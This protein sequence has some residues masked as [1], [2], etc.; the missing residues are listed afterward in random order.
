MECPY[1]VMRRIKG[2][3]DY[4]RTP[5]GM[6]TACRKNRSHMWG[7][8]IYHESRLHDY[9]TFLTLTYDNDNLPISE[10]GYN[11]LVASHVSD[12]MKRLRYYKSDVKVR[13][14]AGGEYGDH[15]FRPHYHLALFGVAP[16]DKTVFKDFRPAESGY[17]CD[18]RA[19]SYG[20][21]NV[22]ELE[23]GSANYIG[24]YCLK[25]VM[26]KGAEEYYKSRGIVPPFARM[27]NRPGIG[28]D[29]MMMY[30]D[31]LLKN[32]TCQ[33]NG[34]TINLP[35][36]YAEKLHYKETDKF[37]SDWWKRQEYLM[38]KFTE[39][40]QSTEDFQG[41]IRKLMD[42]NQQLKWNEKFDER[43]SRNAKI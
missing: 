39:S 42:A 24:G 18:C 36:Y 2:T 4:I 33:V 34:S 32:G 7:A 28:Y 8:R 25:K 35:R 15:T 43:K 22:G 23:Q 14:F 31:E 19:W 29:Y 9:N 16:D 1:A 20:L 11:T 21:A 37:K 5:C 17:N 27:S 38:E 26:G 41:Y 12:F 6:C 3:H 30:A 40:V 13:F 10:C